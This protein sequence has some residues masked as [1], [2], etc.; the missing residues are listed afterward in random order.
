MFIT[1]RQK[2]TWSVPPSADGAFPSVTIEPGQSVEVDKAHWDGVRKGNPVIEALT[3]TRA[4][5]VSRAASAV[6]ADELENPVAPKSA[7]LAPELREL[8]EGVEAQ[9]HHGTAEVVDVP[10]PG[11]GPA[12]AKPSRTRRA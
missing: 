2:R 11:D 6:D 1:N 10:L 9:D 12:E 7:D 5:V 4:L 3:T 8:P